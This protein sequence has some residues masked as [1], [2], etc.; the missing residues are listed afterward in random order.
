LLKLKNHKVMGNKYIK[1]LQLYSASKHLSALTSINNSA[2]F[3][4]KWLSY[5]LLATA[6]ILWI[7]FNIVAIENNQ[8]SPYLLVFMNIIL[9]CIIA[10]MAS[11]DNYTES[12]AA[13]L[14]KQ[15]EINKE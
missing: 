7:T 6:L 15:N 12:N 8:F 3:D 5:F 9:Y 10:A 4:S 13:V 1:Y 11:P 14:Q 2:R